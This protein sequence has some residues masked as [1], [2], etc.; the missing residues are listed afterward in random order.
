MNSFNR[1]L[2]VTTT[3]YLL[4]FFNNAAGQETTK[5]SVKMAES[6]IARS[7]GGITNWDYVSGTI[8]EGFEE[9]WRTTGNEKYYNYIKNSVSPLVKTNGDITG[10]N[11]EEYNMDDVKEGTVILTIYKQTNNQAYKL[12]ADNIREQFYGHPRTNEGGFWHKKVYPWQMWLDGLYM[13]CPFYTEYGRLFNEPEIYDDVMH[14]I[15]QM[16][17]HARDSVTG[18]LYHGWDESRTQAWADPVTGQSPCFWGRGMGWYAMAIVDVLDFLPSQ[19]ENRDTIIGVF[20][21]LAKAI[22]DYQDPVKK[23]WWQVLDRGGDVNNYTESSASCMFVYALAKAIRLGYI[24]QSYKQVVMDG[25][26]GILNEFIEVNPDETINLTK[27]CSGAGLGGSPYRDG[28]YE[29]YTQTALYRK[30]DGKGMGP[31]MM[32]SAEIEMMESLYPVASLMIDSITSSGV[33]LDWSASPGNADSILVERKKDENFEVI[34]TLGSYLSHYKDTSNLEPETIYTYR[35]RSFNESDTSLASNFAIGKSLVTTSSD[36]SESLFTKGFPKGGSPGCILIPEYNNLSQTLTVSFFS[37]NL[38]RADI[39]L[40]DQSG[41]VM[42]K[43]NAERS[44]G[45][46]GKCQFDTAGLTNGIYFISLTT[47]NGIRTEKVII[48]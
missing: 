5:W 28:S 41:R 7:P 13:G 48:F 39:L 15:T 24:N 32:A 22:A 40:I 17:K 20:Q 21:R 43:L 44:M 3:L 36:I 19:N 6:I 14:Q 37:K 42:Q 33:Y 1:L 16:E 8:F 35:I 23:V 18:L 47:E 31:F 11:M 26:N 9:V 46:W 34:A 27:T 12:A 29:Y 30:N 25:Y 45:G 2:L 10:Y 4:S 38:N